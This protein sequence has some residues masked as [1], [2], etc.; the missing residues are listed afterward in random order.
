MPGSDFLL[1]NSLFLIAHFHNAI[2]G[3]VVFGCFAEMTY[4]FLKAFGYTLNETWGKRTFRF[5]IIDFY[6][7]FMPLY[8]LSFMGMTRRLS[9]EIDPIFHPLLMVATASTVLIALGILCQVIQ[10]VISVRDRKKKPRPDGRSMERPYFGVSH[11]LSSA[12][13]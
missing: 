4:W 5:W 3:G 8:V 12:V 1:H 7:A 2:I 13:L 10:I 11:L 6:V 9:Q